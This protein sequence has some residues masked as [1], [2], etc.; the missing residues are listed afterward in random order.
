MT[1]SK[2]EKQPTKVSR[3][4]WLILAAVL[5][6][7]TG[8]VLDL[9]FIPIERFRPEGCGSGY[10]RLSLLVDGR[11]R[12]EQAKREAKANEEIEREH[13][14]KYPDVMLGCRIVTEYRLYVL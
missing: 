10:V 6:G 13:R 2:N 1:N 5:A 11:Q 7:A 8:V 9:V 14:K 12:M 4:F 3:R